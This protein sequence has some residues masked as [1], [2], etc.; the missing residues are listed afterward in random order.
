MILQNAINVVV[1]MFSTF[2]RGEINVSK[3]GEVL[4]S[5]GYGVR[6]MNVAGGI[7]DN[8][9]MA[10]FNDDMQHNVVEVRNVHWEG[11]QVSIGIKGLQVL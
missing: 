2:H 6:T 9:Y 11:A 10:Y 4:Q 8:L 1:N 3:I 7:P 5:L